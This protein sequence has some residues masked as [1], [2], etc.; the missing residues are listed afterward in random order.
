[1]LLDGPLPL[2]FNKRMGRDV[3]DVVGYVTWLSSDEKT[4]MPAEEV[5]SY[6]KERL[7]VPKP[8]EETKTQQPPTET[9]SSQQ[10]GRHGRSWTDERPI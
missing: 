5:L 10:D 1:M 8:K 3:Q 2:V 9:P 4:Y 7:A 6:V